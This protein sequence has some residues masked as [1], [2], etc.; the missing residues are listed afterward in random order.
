MKT[1]KF[2]FLTALFIL[3]SFTGV[4]S[5][6]KKPRIM[7]VPDRNWCDRQ[8][9]MSEWDNQGI[10][11]FVPDYN[12]AFVKNAD[13]T[14]VLAVIGEEMSKDNFN[15]LLLRNELD[16][17]KRRAA[18]NTARTSK[19]GANIAQS[20]Y[21]ELLQSANADIIIELWW[22]VK[23]LSGDKHVDFRLTGIDAASQTQIANASGEGEPSGATSVS[24]LLR[25]AAHNYMGTF[26][27]GLQRHFNDLLV[28]GRE[29]SFELYVW[30]D[31]FD[32]GLPDGL[33][34]EFDGE[35]L[36]R[37]IRKW[38][39][40]NTVKGRFTADHEQENEIEYA[41]VRIPL[42]DSDEMAMNARD[43]IYGL[44]KMLRDKYKIES[45]SYG[46]G[47]GKVI[48]DIGGK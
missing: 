16:E 47:T 37:I 40:Q 41:Q 39:V 12:T 10:K 31:A 22:E 33:D 3:L 25:E 18:R 1:T 17:L 48:L 21:D 44:S 23:T 36:N 19:R 11:E 35:P 34:T 2:L 24:T 13:L 45:R 4:Y 5:Q 20:P 42:F 26:Q 30:D 15:L 14:N 32:N 46:I 38:M 8:G 9:F 27:Q 43:W 29:I 7:V 6:A 28:N